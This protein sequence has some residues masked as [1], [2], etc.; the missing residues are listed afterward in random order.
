M[1]LPALLAPLLSLASVHAQQPCQSAGE[2]DAVPGRHIDAA[3]CEW[4][5]QRASWLDNMKTPARKAVA[6]TALTQIEN[7]EKE[8]RKNFLLTGGV[9]KSSF[10]AD[11]GCLYQRKQIGATYAFQL[12]C[13]RY[14]CIRNKQEVSGEYSTVLRATV[15]PRF[16]ALFSNFP[17]EGKFS[18]MVFDEGACTK[19]L[20][21]FE[22]VGF[23]DPKLIQVVNGEGG[24]YQDI[25]EEKEKKLPS[26]NGNYITRTWYITKAGKSPFLPVSRR[27]FLESLLAYYEKEKS[28]ASL[29]K[30]SVDQEFARLSAKG[31]NERWYHNK[32][33][34]YKDYE[35]AA[36]TKKA[37]VQKLLQEQPA[38]WL[39]KPAVIDN[40][41]S[42]LTDAGKPDYAGLYTF[43]AFAISES[44]SNVNRIYRYNPDYFV[45]DPSGKPQ[46]IRVTFRYVKVPF[47]QR[48]AT[49]FTDTFDRAAWQKLL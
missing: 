45:D 41:K 27:E 38:D 35:K 11:N 20:D 19:G 44:G 1:K 18:Q 42:W 2:L 37:T 6:N 4:P 49:N 23:Q 32:L 47:D 3:H 8:S 30:I 26:G 12:G 31:Y 14:I 5:A 22:Y 43:V 28:V 21:L 34:P 15:N 10:S 40:M 39:A 17:F 25:P 46:L 33:G 48:I 29:Y 9:L 7:L 16:S 13:Y 36:A 24:Y